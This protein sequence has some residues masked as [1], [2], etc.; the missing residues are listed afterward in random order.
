MDF[1]HNDHGY[2]TGFMMRNTLLYLSITLATVL[3]FSSIVGA[4]NITVY[5]DKAQWEIALN[6]PFLT[7]AFADNLL[8]VGVSFV[9]TE[10]SPQ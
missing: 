5:T 10:F 9:S 4:S 8:N 6:R 3:S 1:N 7:E 2:I